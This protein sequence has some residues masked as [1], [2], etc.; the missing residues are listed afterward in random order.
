MPALYVESFVDMKTGTNILLDSGACDEGLDIADRLQK[1]LLPAC[2]E[3]RQNIIQKK[4]RRIPCLFLYQLNFRQLQ[5]ERRTPLL[6]LGTVMSQIHLIGQKY[7]AS[8]CG[9]VIVLQR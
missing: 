7:K 4:N 2:V 5:G 9:P 8:L 1:R 3:L 6:P